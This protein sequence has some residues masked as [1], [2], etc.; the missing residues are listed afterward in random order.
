V[1]LLEIYYFIDKFH[2]K[3]NYVMQQMQ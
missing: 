3:K 1:E 2:R